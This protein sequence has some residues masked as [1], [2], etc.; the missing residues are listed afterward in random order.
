MLFK[1]DYRRSPLPLWVAVVAG[2][3]LVVVLAWWTVESASTEQPDGRETIVFWGGTQ[4]GEDI[5]AVINDFEQRFVDEHGKPKYKV[6]MGTAVARNLTGDAQRLMCAVAGGVPPDVVFFDRFATGEWA[7]RGALTDLRPFLAAQDP[8]NNPWD[9]KYAVNLA[10]YYPWAVT[11]ASYAPPGSSEEPGVYGVPTTADIRVLFS[12]GDLLRQEGMV[13]DRGEPRPPQTWEE[14]REAT[15][16]LT[17]YT[18]RDDPSSG[19]QRLGFAPNYGNSWLYMYAWQAGGEFMSPDRT[20]VTLDS[21]PVVRALKYM[22]DLYDDVGGYARVNAYQSS[23]QTG[24][25]DP[26]LKGQVAMKIDGEWSLQSLVDWRPNMDVIITPAPMP[27]DELAKGRQPITWA[28]G[29]SLVVPTTAQNKAGAFR[30]IQ[31]LTS[32]EVVLRLEQGKREQKESEGRLYIPRTQANR[33]TFEEMLRLHIHGNPDVPPRVRQ[34]FDVYRELLPTTLI[35]PVTPVGQL[36][37]E[38]HR[39][40]YENGVSHIYRSEAER[41]RPELEKQDVA[42]L[43]QAAVAEGLTDLVATTDKAALV[44]AIIGARSQKIALRH[45][46]NDVQRLLDQI[47]QPAPPETRVNWTPYLWAYAALVLMPFAAM[48]VTY[49][50]RKKAY[51]YKAREVGAAMV[52]ASPWIVGFVVFVGGP[53]LFSMVIAFTR[54]DV[55]NPGHYVG[56][57]NFRQIASDPLF[58][59]SLGNTAFMVLRVPLTMAASLAI[60]MLLNRGIRGIGFYRTGFYMPAIVP[61]VASSLLWLWIFNPSHGVLNVALTWLFETRLFELLGRLFG[62]TFTVPLW[63][64]D[65]NWS[66]P[67][68]ILMNLWAAGGGMIIWLA[69][70]QSIPEQLYEAA[71]I[72]GAS[73]WRRFWHV[74]VP[75]LSPYILFNAIIGVIG[76]MQVFGE[77]FIMTEGG[78]NDSTL[79][80]AYHLFKQAFQFFR[81]GYASALAWILFAIVLILTLIQLWAS[82]KWVHYEQA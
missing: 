60:A 8:Q 26:F 66:K 68:L 64:Q 19:I 13:D 36:L 77:A 54:Y 80:Y 48:F 37:W 81:M 4:L 71:S 45:A 74:T 76:T 29:W 52:F 22:T 7:G 47:L 11:E 79:F 75:M 46:Q 42:A 6:I 56:L 62:T 30:L 39:S 57:D 32:T 53:I 2:L 44:E 34:A 40:A 55:I 82:K 43:Q 51:S 12:N 18:R 78:P 35:R 72:D 73:P 65:P 16:R 25:L 69:G 20:R 38:M 50:R 41:D 33:K 49:R 24:E 23:F 67:S 14:L 5:Y 28:G 31:F 1:A 9:A 10:D 59:K 63:L 21:P 58:L 70:L 3:V 15:R 27:S 61:L 17:R